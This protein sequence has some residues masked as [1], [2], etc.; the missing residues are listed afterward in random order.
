M[1]EDEAARLTP[2]SL[3]KYFRLGVTSV[4]QLSA[5]LEARLEIDP[6]T[7]QLR[8]FVPATGGTP[9]V[10]DFERIR[11]DRLE[12]LAGKASFRLAFDARGMHYPAYQLIESIV[13]HLREGDSFRA[14][15]S[16]S[17]AD[18]E[19]LLA[20][21]S[22]LSDE[23]ETGLW[24]EMLL[25]EHLVGR[26]GDSIASEVWLGAAGS[27]HDFSFAGFE[28][29]VKTT[30]SEA[31]RHHISSDTQLHPSPGRDLYLVSIQ[32][33]LAG[34]ASGGR[35]LPKI[36][37]DIR[38][39]LTSSVD[40]FDAAL[41]DLGYRYED[42]DLYRTELQLRSTPRAYFVDDDFP[43]VTRSRIEA[44][45]PNLQ[46]ISDLRYQVDVGGLAHAAI[47]APLNDFCEIPA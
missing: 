18:M 35:T 29:E 14:A 26:L 4:F 16:E 36:V 7:E 43:S 22:R 27:E 44:V 28:A 20:N 1:S 40:R 3:E 17:I 10:T 12:D 38:S 42:A 25:L 37:E 19:D 46:L 2:E 39:V 11:V 32:A 6:S 41:H 21:R 8:L 23:Q 31:R 33:T 34:A 30:R 45:V 47:P 15:V 24:G 9:E 13:S 5:D